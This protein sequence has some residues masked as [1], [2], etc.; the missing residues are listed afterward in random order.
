MAET[1]PQSEKTITLAFH[2]ELADRIEQA[3][4]EDGL[5]LEQVVV[6]WLVWGRGRMHPAT[7]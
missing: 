4:R 2:A 6:G 7:R 1:K 3:L 5:T